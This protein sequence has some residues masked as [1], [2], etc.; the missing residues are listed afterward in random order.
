MLPLMLFQAVGL[1]SA[2]V[3]IIRSGRGRAGAWLVG[4][5]LVGLGLHLC[6]S[7]FLAQGPGLMPWGFVIATALEMLT[8]LGMVTLYYEHARA[9]LLDAQRALA[10][11]RRVEALGR[12]AGG[13]AHDFNNML[14]VMQGHLDLLRP[15]LGGGAE[16]MASMQT[17]E[18]AVRQAGRLTAQLLAFGRRS[19]IQREAI[20]VHRVIA[21]SLE[22]LRKVIPSNIEVDF[23][24]SEA[25]YAASMD[26]S[27]LEQIVLNLVTNARDAISGAGQ[28]TI[29]LSR[30][31]SPSPTLLLCVSDTG[32]GMEAN[33]LARVFEPF[34]TTKADGRG[35]GLGLASVQGAVNQLGG[36]IRVES[37][38]G[39]G[40]RFEV[41]LPL[42]V[43]AAMPLEPVTQGRT[44]PLDILLVDDAERVREVSARLLERA[45]HRVHQASNGAEAL[46][47]I[48]ARRYDV[49][50][51]DVVMPRM[52]GLEL[53]RAAARLR[54]D[55][56]VVLT[57][58]YPRDADVQS[59]A[60]HFLPKPF[61]SRVLLETLERLVAE[62]RRGSGSRQHAPAPGPSA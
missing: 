26:R 2:G 59:P 33:V 12:V 52:G 47:M 56:V 37:W 29:A 40:T 10:E 25:Q 21:E 1:A 5:S 17:M 57:S 48:R 32:S 4:A 6:G 55:A 42:L 46:E 24:S 20:D 31:D 11:T 61:E 54:P 8:A 22:L 19:V 45:G 39:K 38:P 35:T 49:V 30:T 41:R 51:S 50:L 3:L 15:Q 34:F 62:P 16:V 18:Q 28:I 60:V 27:L 53:A 58:G 13:V 44:G 43:A 36:Q 7:L 23:Q 14:T 9:Q